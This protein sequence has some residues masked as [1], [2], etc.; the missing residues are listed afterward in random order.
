MLAAVVKTVVRKKRAE[1]R[2]T[3]GEEVFNSEMNQ[4]VSGPSAELNR[5]NPVEVGGAEDVYGG[6]KF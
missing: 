1:A 6:R 5:I 2:V 3:R 4:D